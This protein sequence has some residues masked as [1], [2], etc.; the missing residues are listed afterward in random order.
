MPQGRKAP[1]LFLDANVLFSAAYRPEGR[2][3]ALFALAGRGRCSLLT[4]AYAVT[5][6]DRN[7]RHKAP[8]ALK[9]LA[10]LLDRMAIVAGPDQA[11]QARAALLG[12]DPGD[13]PI[14][15]AAF[16]T[17]EI[18]VTGDRKHFAHLMGRPVKGLRIMDPGT[19]L[20]E[21]L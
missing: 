13:V 3:A 20:A 8:E 5:E 1:R 18:L 4:S 9:A 6:A 16:G 11:A 7:L 17:C 10:S 14:L 12:L 19:A 21:L 2:C 15:G